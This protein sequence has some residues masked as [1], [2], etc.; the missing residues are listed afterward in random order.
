M[1]LDRLQVRPLST[2]A[3][4]L[5]QVDLGRCLFRSCTA[6]SQPD[7]PLEHAH[8]RVLGAMLFPKVES[9]TVRA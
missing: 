4:I 8:V 9:L 6:C 2:D 1:T 5:P 3:R 7:N